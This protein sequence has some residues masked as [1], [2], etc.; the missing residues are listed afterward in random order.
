MS[1]EHDRL[2]TLVLE[3]RELGSFAQEKDVASGNS[4]EAAIMPNSQRL[5]T[6]L[7]YLGQ[8]FQDFWTEEF[9]GLNIIER[10]NLAVLTAKLCAVGVCALDLAGCALWLFKQALQT[11]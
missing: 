2:V 10:E 5:W 9:I 7:P 1:T 3:V 11:E 4:Q 8:D 6:D